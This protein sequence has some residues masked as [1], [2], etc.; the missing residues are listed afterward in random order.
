MKLLV[1]VA[2]IAVT[3]QMPV[4]YALSPQMESQSD[5]ART[6]APEITKLCSGDGTLNLNEAHRLRDYLGSRTTHKE[7]LLPIDDAISDAI[8]QCSMSTGV[9]AAIVGGLRVVLG[10][11]LIVEKEYSRAK[12]VFETA[13]H[14]FTR[15][16]APSLMWLAALQ[17]E[18]QAELMLG[19]IQKADVI[20]SNQADMAREWVDKQH[21]ASGALVDA[22]RFEAKIRTAEDQGESATQLMREAN[23]LESHE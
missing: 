21:F 12:E 2:M 22:L 1:V 18:A 14:L 23:R 7:Q 8:K 3:S 11:R 5:S 9:D 4:G 16:G 13:D 6:A 17:G 19:N 20:A 10:N 15:F